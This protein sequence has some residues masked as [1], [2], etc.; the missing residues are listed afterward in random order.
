[1]NQRLA[2]VFRLSAL[3][4]AAMV[5]TTLPAMAAAE[6]SPVEQARELL[7]LYAYEAHASSDD[8]FLPRKVT[9]DDNGTRHVRMERRYRGLRVIGGEV[10]VNMDAT[11]R[12]IDL[13]VSLPD[14]VSL[15][16][17][18]ANVSETQA[19]QFAEAAFVGHSDGMARTER[20]IYARAGRPQLAY[21]VRM[22]GR[23]DGAA[24]AVHHFVIDAVQMR[25]LD[26]WDE[27]GSSAT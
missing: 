26:Q 1:M 12:L 15:D 21:D 10:V 14:T 6:L 4:V 20:V 25:L 23:Y 19:L 13:D 22:S 7:K 9:S 27:A 16:S 18:E 11:G 17:L 3:S 8:R 24:H 2:R 5:A